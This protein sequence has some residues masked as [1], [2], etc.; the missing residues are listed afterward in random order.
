MWR[1]TCTFLKPACVVANED[2]QHICTR[3]GH[4]AYHAQLLVEQSHIDG[5]HLLESSGEARDWQ[6]RRRRQAREQGRRER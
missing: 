1:E 5:A 6:G 3:A 4:A 2:A